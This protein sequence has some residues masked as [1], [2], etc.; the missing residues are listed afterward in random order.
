[1]PDYLDLLTTR[2]L[3]SV[4]Q[5]CEEMAVPG[6]KPPTA[7]VDVGSTVQGVLPAPGEILPMAIM[8]LLFVGTAIWIMARG[9][10]LKARQASG[11]MADGLQ[12]EVLC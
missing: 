4:L 1:M 12:S 5:A 11:Q 7:P 3:S 10:E 9:S 2:L 6:G 8:V